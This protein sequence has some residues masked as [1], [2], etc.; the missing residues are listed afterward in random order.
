M[1]NDNKM[2][3]PMGQGGLVRYFDEVKSKIE[4]SPG[5]VIILCFAI[6]AIIVLL[7]Y[8]GGALLK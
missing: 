4:F 7:H 3:M 2:R 5:V 8:F 1:A 6:I